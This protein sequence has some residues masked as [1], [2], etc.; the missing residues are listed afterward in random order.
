LL[1]DV[2]DGTGLDVGWQALE[3]IAV[4]MEFFRPEAGELR[5][6]LADALGFAD[7]F[8]IDIGEVADVESAQAAGFEG[9]AEDI[10][11]DKSAEISDVSRA[12]DRGSAAVKPESPSVERRQILDFSCQSIIQ[13]HAP[14]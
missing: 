4:V 8:V 13:T 14:P 7:R 1:G 12:I 6:C 5:E 2:L 10:L 9:A 11:E 3:Q